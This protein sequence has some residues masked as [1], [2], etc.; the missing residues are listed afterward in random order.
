MKISHIVFRVL[1]SRQVKASGLKIVTIKS[2][3]RASVDTKFGS[4]YV[5][6]FGTFPWEREGHEDG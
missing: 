1:W 4:R 5:L 3:R 6:T 2:W